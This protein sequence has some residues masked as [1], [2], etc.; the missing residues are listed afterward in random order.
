VLT[1]TSDTS[2]LTVVGELVSGSIVP[3]F[4]SI[5][6]TNNI[7]TQG[8]GTMTAGG[9]FTAVG[10]FDAKGNVNLGDTADDDI[11]MLG[12]V[13]SDLV[14]DPYRPLSESLLFSYFRK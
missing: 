6:T 11:I 7:E 12:T 2:S 5:V 1:T 8:G 9:A 4:G 13:A 14:S 10:N 3:G